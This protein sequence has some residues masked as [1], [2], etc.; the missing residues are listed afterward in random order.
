MR[1]IVKNEKPEQEGKDKSNM[2]DRIK[3]ERWKVEQTWNINEKK[4]KEQK[5]QLE[6]RNK[7]ERKKEDRDVEKRES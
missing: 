3:E 4:R 6:H 1:N 5:Q 2:G 7:K